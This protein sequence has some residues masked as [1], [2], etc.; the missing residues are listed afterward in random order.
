MQQ[1]KRRNAAADLAP[2]KSGREN[3]AREHFI[4][5]VQRILQGTVAHLTYDPELLVVVQ[6]MPPRDGCDSL[7]QQ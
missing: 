5:R 2:F 4:A 1:L 7:L 3:R 6:A